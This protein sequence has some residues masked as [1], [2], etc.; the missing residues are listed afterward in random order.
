MRTPPVIHV[1]DVLVLTPCGVV[2]AHEI[3]VLEERLVAPPELD[4]G[5]PADHAPVAGWRVGGRVVDGVRRVD[6]S[7]SHFGLQC[8]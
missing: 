6:D 7:D 8:S 4:S 2:S 3:H 1:A 5:L